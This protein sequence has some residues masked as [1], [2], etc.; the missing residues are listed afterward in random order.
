MSHPQSE[1]AS[2]APRLTPPR[3]LLLLGVLAA[4]AVAVLFG[5]PVLG[6]MFGPKP[7]PAEAPPP[8]GTFKPTAEQLATLKIVTV[9]PVGF[10]PGV[11][12]E[13]K[14]ATDD[15]H[16]TQVFSPY[17]GRVTRVMAKA[18]DAVRA[19]QPL[20]AIE[21]SE[22]VQAQNDLVAARAQLDLA[23]AAEH[24]Q[25]ELF[26]INGAAEKD[27]RQSQADLV[28][29]ETALGAVRGRLRIL[30]QTDAQIAALEKRPLGQSVSAETIVPSPIGGVVI[31]KSVGPGQ[32]LGSVTNGGTSPAFVVSD[33]SSVWLVG[34]LREVDAPKA[35][36]GQA[37]EVRVEALPG[38]VFA[39]KV[40]YVA[41]T[42]DPVSRRVL[43]R[44]AVSN[45]G[46]VLKPEMFAQF[47][48]LTGG[49]T[50][51]V[52]A[53]EEAVIYEADTARVWVARPGG[54]LELRQIKTGATEGGQVEVLSGLSPGERI[55]TSGALFIDRAAKG[56]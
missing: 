37:V 33:L 40:S 49:Q 56:D 53:P 27:W 55:V 3:Q 34:Q 54:L 38:Q 42:V 30:G 45:P 22:F 2:S 50:S 47:R 6:K 28:N 24:R 7:P 31:Q 32:N 48:L 46:G 10:R 14:V 11:E 41:P 9:E 5:I 13:G 39:G 36:V 21:A 51:V 12:T 43:V 16:T 1:A 35:R 29:A 8:P 15:D 23:K 26:K 20:F 25:G 17:S 44:A 52:A 18:G 4:L 19:G